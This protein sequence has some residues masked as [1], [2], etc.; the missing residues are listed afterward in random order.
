MEEAG[1]EKE[2]IGTNLGSIRRRKSA[3]PINIY[4]SSHR[5]VPE[6]SLWYA[7]ASPGNSRGGPGV[8]GQKPLVR[9]EGYGGVVGPKW[10]LRPSTS[11]GSLSAVLT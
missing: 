8:P 1:F 6:K 10:L 7:P 4:I 2:L 11:P 9:Q 5:G 3:K